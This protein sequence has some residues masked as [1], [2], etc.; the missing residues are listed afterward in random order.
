MEDSIRRID[1]IDDH[2]LKLE[3]SSGSIALV[4]MRQRMDGI[5]FQALSDPDVFKT[6]RSDGDFAVWRTPAGEL[7]ASVR[8]LLDTM[9]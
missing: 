6:V 7:R 9:L 5:R 4:N 3:L 2:L 1:V 8:E